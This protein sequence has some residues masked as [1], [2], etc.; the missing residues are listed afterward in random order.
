M[1]TNI[2]ITG[3]NR[4]IGLEFVRQLRAAS[5][6]NRIIGTARDPSAARDLKSLAHR[7][8]PLDIAD[9]KSIDSLAGA[10]ADTPIDILINNAAIG[11]EKSTFAELDMD[12]LA[13]A[14]RINSVGPMR[15]AQN[16]LPNLRKGKRKTI[17]NITT[18]CAS[19]EEQTCT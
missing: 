14:F 15:V 6:D 9:P 16:L 10:L 2:L 12:K 13:D 4:G 3:A 8:E 11:P 7:V 19:I 1:T 5:P 18:I 17:V